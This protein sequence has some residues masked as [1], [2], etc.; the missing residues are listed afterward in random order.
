MSQK[1]ANFSLNEK[2]QKELL[3]I[4]RKALEK[5]FK[6]E[7]LLEIQSEL[8]SL[9]EKVGA[10]VTLSKEEKLSGCIGHI[11]SP[12]PLFETSSNSPLLQL[13]KIPDLIRL[14]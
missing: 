4:A 8:S 13:R 5:F 2:E 1:M 11:V 7:S 12:L 6:K 14:L 9:Q 10:F 3:S